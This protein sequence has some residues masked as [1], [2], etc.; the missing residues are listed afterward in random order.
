MN[1]LGFRPSLADELVRREVA[2]G[3]EL[4]VVAVGDHEQ[5]QVLSQ[6]VL[7]TRRIKSR[8]GRASSTALIELFLLY[9]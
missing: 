3:L 5:L 7:A 1:R 4:A 8:R 6:L 9:G 2:Q